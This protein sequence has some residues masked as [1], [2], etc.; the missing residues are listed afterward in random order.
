MKKKLSIILTVYNKE[1]FLNRILDCLLNQIDV[2]IDSY[3]VLAVNDGSTDNSHLILE[4]YASRYQAIRVITQNN[5]G[6]SL[7]R[8]NGLDAAC[9]DY[10]WFVDAD[11]IIYPEAVS[12]I[13]KAID[14]SPDVIPIYAKFKGSDYIY[15]FINDSCKTGKDVLLEKWSHCGV[16]WILRKNFLIDNNL[17][18]YPGIYHEDSEFTP[19]MLYTAKTVKVIPKVLYYVD[20]DP[21]SITQIPRAKR[22]FDCLIVAEHIFEFKESHKEA[23]TIIGKVMDY[24]VSVMLNNGLDVIVRNSSEDQ[25]H[26]NNAL[27]EK[28][29]LFK[30]LISSPSMKHKSEGILFYIFPTHYVSIYKMIKFL[31]NLF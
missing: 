28:K 23:G 25:E 21:E 1:I 9:G 29:R 14:L 4:E 3:E 7:A 8:N 30:A 19:R 6:L 31:T 16:F 13:L 11:D 18:F 26:F 10:V 15:N 5:Q 12:L 20:C 17:K 22:S 2:D 27:Y 24:N